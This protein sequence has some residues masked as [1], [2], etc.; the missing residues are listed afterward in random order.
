MINMG[1]IYSELELYRPTIWS[2]QFIFKNIECKKPGAF[3][4]I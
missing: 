1:K 4:I 2:Q 3:A